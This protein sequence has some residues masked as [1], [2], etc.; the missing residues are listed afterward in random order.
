MSDDNSIPSVISGPATDTLIK[1]L[2]DVLGYY[3]E[4]SSII[5]KQKALNEAEKIKL[6]G[7]YELIELE[8]KLIN[9]TNFINLKKAKNFNSIVNKSEEF[10]EESAKPAYIEHDWIVKFFESASLVSDEAMQHVWARILAGEANNPGSF[11]RRTIRIVSEM[12]KDE[13]HI[14]ENVCRFCI[15]FP[16]GLV[17]PV[18]S[19]MSF[20]DEKFRNIYEENGLLHNHVTTLENIGLVMQH[21]GPV[22]GNY[23]MKYFG[24]EIKVHDIYKDRMNVGGTKFTQ[25]GSELQK[26]CNSTPAKGF[27]EF[28]LSTFGSLP[29]TFTQLIDPS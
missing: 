17:I 8:D 2:R 9:Q 20:C 22:T 5:R 24:R 1:L 28:L 10:I 13:A 4:P 19:G 3:M 26:I 11:S 18:V 25:S 21:G 16:D 29:P 6:I 23:S 7:K 12:A 15:N 14:F 27:Y